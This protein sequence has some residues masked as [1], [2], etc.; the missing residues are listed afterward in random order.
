MRHLITLEE[1]RVHNINVRSQSPCTPSVEKFFAK[2]NYTAQQEL[3]IKEMQ[4]AFRGLS[5]KFE[6]I[7]TING[8]IADRVNDEYI[9]KDIL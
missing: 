9:W 4:Y 2:F 6:K 7:V 1:R 8:A 5:L 3:R